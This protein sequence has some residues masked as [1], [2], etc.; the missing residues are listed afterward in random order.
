MPV[1][2][3]DTIGTATMALSVLFKLG[4][5]ILLI[6]VSLYLLKRWQTG[7]LPGSVK[8]LSILETTHLSPRQAL[9]LVKV[10]SQVFLIGA[11]D[12]TISY[13][14]QLENS[15]PDLQPCEG[16]ATASPCERVAETFARLG[17]DGKQPLPEKLKALP[18]FT[19][20]L[21]SAFG[22]R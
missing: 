18:N 2:G 7:K 21:A 14:L 11:T 16:C 10:D 5:V 9:H 20:I 8:K 12:Q 15:Q 3:S 13:L 4:F 1:P 22:K 19:S 6:Y 17:E